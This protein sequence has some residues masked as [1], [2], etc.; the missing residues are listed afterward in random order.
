MPQINDWGVVMGFDA[1]AVD[2]GLADL[3]SKFAKFD[4]ETRPKGGGGAGGKFSDLQREGVR[5]RIARAQAGVQRKHAQLANATDSKSIAIK[6][7]LQTE[8]NRLA[9]AQVSLAGITNRNSTA[10]TNLVGSLNRSRLAV[11]GLG[12]EMR[13]LQT[14]ANKGSTAIGGFASRLSGPLAVAIG[15]SAAGLIGL[16]RTMLTEAKKLDSLKASMLAAS[17]SAEQAG[18]DFKFISDTSKEL[19]RDLLTSARGFQQIGTAGRAAGF[20]ADD[21]KELF[22]AASEGSTAFGLSMEDTQGV[23]RAFSQIMSK[24]TVQAE[25]LR[26]QLG[27]RLFGAFNLYA[28]SLGLTTDELNKQLKAGKVASSTII[29]FAKT[30]RAATRESGALAA[31][32][33]A[34]VAAQNRAATARTEMTDAFLEAGG[35]DA[36]SD[37][38]GLLQDFWLVL[39]PIASAIG[40]AFKVVLGLL[41]GITSLVTIAIEPITTI[42]GAIGKA[43]ANL[44]DVNNLMKDFTGEAESTD[45]AFA[46]LLDKTG[47]LKSTLVRIWGIVKVVKGLFTLMGIEIDR[48]FA[49]L[50]DLKTIGI[51]DIGN[52]LFDAAGNYANKGSKALFGSTPRE[53]FDSITGG[54]APKATESTGNTVNV[55]IDKV[56]ASAE[57]VANE[58]GNV[59]QSNNML[60][61]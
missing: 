36:L 8:I 42:V 14:S 17:G 4:Q 51:G 27:D 16:G 53:A 3:K 44:W 22:L 34:I 43:A 10:Y 26:G 28:E 5:D 57:E 20:A 23:F 11:S 41:K 30:L 46:S 49:P 47:F 12:H 58:V 61:R 25:E 39:R 50:R 21:I 1:S 29:G 2:R 13:T 18:L 6:G 15:V 60:I 19:G 31:G 9:A 37:M 24:G 40:P 59:M 45:E 38:Y 32:M 48:A 35:K 55:N 33:V 54:G 52:A 56:L 7:R